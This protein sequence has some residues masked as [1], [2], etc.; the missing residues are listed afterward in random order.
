[1]RDIQAIE[2]QFIDLNNQEWKYNFMFAVGD[3]IIYL[4]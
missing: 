1:M 2:I 3:N 4:N